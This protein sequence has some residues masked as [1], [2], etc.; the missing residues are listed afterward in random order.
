MGVVHQNVHVD[1]LKEKGERIASN[2]RRITH[3]KKKMS[4][5]KI[6]RD[7]AI[8]AAALERIAYGEEMLS[9]FALTISLSSNPNVIEYSNLRKEILELENQIVEYYRNIQIGLRNRLTYTETP[10]IYVYYG[11]SDN[12]ILTKN[13]ITSEIIELDPEKTTIFPQAELKS[14]RKL[15]HFYNQTSFKYLEELSKDNS[16]SLEEK[17]IGKVRVLT[18]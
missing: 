9:Y 10:D 5:L 11:T 4:D 3:L 2:R 14:K 8:Y 17:N 16:F 12:Q 7:V 13:I 6:D 1:N 18:K 15:R